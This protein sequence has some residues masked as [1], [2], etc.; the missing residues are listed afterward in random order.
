MSRSIAAMR[1]ASI[2]RDDSLGGDSPWLIQLYEGTPKAWFLEDYRETRGASSHP[3]AVEIVSEWI[4]R[5]GF[6]GVR[7]PSGHVEPGAPI[8]DP[9]D[10]V[11]DLQALGDE[12]GNWAR[13]AELVTELAANW[14]GECQVCGACSALQFCA[15]C[16]CAQEG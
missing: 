9:I 10:I 16:G 6:Y 14:F 8:R 7:T 11:A 1:Y 5:T 13:H 4:S 15:A 2:E 12:P 3:E